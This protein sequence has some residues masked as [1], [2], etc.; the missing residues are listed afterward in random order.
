MLRFRSW[1][2][3]SIY[4][5]VVYY[6]YDLLLVN[7]KKRCK[8]RAKE[9]LFL[10]LLLLLLLLKLKRVKEFGMWKD[11]EIDQMVDHDP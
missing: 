10:L 4:L 5:L 7:K 2:C 11:D 9:F 6:L 3:W 1:T 8:A